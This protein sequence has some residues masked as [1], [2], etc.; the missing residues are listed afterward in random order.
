M[1]ANYHCNLR[2]TY[3]LTESSPG[4]P[5]R[6]LT[7]ETMVER[8]RE[9]GELG[10]TSL[11]VTGGEPF[12]LDW[13]PDLIAELAG[14]LPVVALSS[15]TLFTGRRLAALEALSGL[16]VKIQISLD[17]PDPDPATRCAGRR[18]SPRWS[19]RSRSRSPGA[20]A[21]VTRTTLGIR[22]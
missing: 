6:L 15:G 22:R 1:Y 16:P 14:I 12:L 9:A 18:A 21:S 5:R 2:C 13:M 7:R 19:P 20:S 10:F 3:C 11:G 17:R 8:A 4:V